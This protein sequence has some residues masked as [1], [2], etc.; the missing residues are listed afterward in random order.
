MD[1]VVQPFIAKDFSGAVLVGVHGTIVF[2]KAYGL[3]DREAGLPNKT[4]TSYRAAALSRLFVATAIVILNDKHKL[5]I[6]NTA[7]QFVPGAGAV[8]IRDLLGHDDDAS[9]DLLARIIVASRQK[10]LADALN[11]LMFGPLWMQGSSVE[12]V[13]IGSRL[14]KDYGGSPASAGAVFTTSR[15][16]MRW[17]RAYFGDGLISPAGREILL[18]N[19]TGWTRIQNGTTPCWQ[20]GGRGTALLYCPGTET[21]V[22]V[23]ANAGGDSS[24]LLAKDLWGLAA[25]GR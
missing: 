5:S 1:G 19:P 24:G 13:E 18:G 3:A 2:D 9:T 21:A 15:D 14:A 16:L 22:M 10:T 7:E 4:T 11:D 25:A 17:V 20:A 8:T 6:D 23:L 12:A